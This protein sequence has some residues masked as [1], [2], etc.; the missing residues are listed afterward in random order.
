VDEL[1]PWLESEATSLK[2]RVEGVMNAPLLLR[3]DWDEARSRLGKSEAERLQKLL[4]LEMVLLKSVPGDL[5]SNI[6][7]THLTDKYPK[8]TLAFNGKNDYPDIFLKDR[9]YSFL[10]VRTRSQT[11]YGAAIKGKERRPVRIPD[12]LEVKTCRNVARVDCHHAHIGLHLLVVYSERN[13]LCQVSDVLL[14][15]L[16][17]ADY[18]ESQRRTPATT[19][20]QSFGSKK[21]VSLL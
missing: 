11:E 4:D 9:D 20:K 19:A 1:V 18:K 12:G 6:V 14:A 21:F 5:V 2:A 8:P 13:K 15:F 17:Q 3:R 10:P 7:V 16:S